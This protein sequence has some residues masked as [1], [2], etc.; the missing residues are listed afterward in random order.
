MK[1]LQSLYR[2]DV[3]PGR[4]QT[5]GNWLN[6]TQ[7][8]RKPPAALHKLKELT[9]YK[10]PAIISGNEEKG[11]RRSNLR[12][13]SPVPKESQKKAA[14]FNFTIRNR[15]PKISKHRNEEEIKVKVDDLI[16][17]YIKRGMMPKTK[18]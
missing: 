13:V 5:R 2:K 15:S 9:E 11:K 1:D 17:S 7:H 8:N 16:L 18:A 6:C 12:K 3:L 14:N 10:S 4:K